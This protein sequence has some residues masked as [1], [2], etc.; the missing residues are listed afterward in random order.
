MIKEQLNIKNIGRYIKLNNDLALEDP[1]ILKKTKEEFLRENKS[2]LKSE[3]L[4][5]FV[6]THQNKDIGFIIL[7]CENQTIFIEELFIKQDYRYLTSYKELLYINNL[8][9]DYNC[10]ELIKYVGVNDNQYLIDAFHY[11]NYYMEKEHIQMEKNIK[12][13][14]ASTNSEIEKK[15]FFEIKDSKWIYN[16]MKE[17]MPQVNNNYSYKEINKLT[18]KSDSLNFIFYKNGFPLGFIVAFINKQRNLQQKQNVIYIEEIAVHK[19]F[20]NYGYGNQI[21]KFIIN[22]GKDKGMNLARLHVYRNNKIAYKLY[23]KLGFKEVKSI[24]HWIYQTQVQSGN[25]QHNYM[26][27]NK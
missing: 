11:Y 25:K 24:G 6:L 8:F 18:E 26:T 4:L 27:E 23:Q 12:T 17:C 5:V 1:Y 3:N 15:S 10:Y 14:Y 9:V 22:K 7:N 16:F 13:E 19:Q 21:L 2:R 20:R